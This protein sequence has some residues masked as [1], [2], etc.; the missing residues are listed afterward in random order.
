MT[1]IP[2]YLLRI[3]SILLVMLLC[4]RPVI[5]QDKITPTI[6]ADI[7]SQ[8]ISRGINDGDF[9]LQPSLGLSYKGLSLLAWGNCGISNFK[10][11][12]ELDITLS[13]TRWNITIGVTDNWVDNVDTFDDDGNPVERKTKY[14]DY[15]D[16]AG[17]VYE[18]FLGYDLGFLSATWYTNFAGDDGRTGRGK[19]AYSSYVELNS[20][21]KAFTCDWIA[22]LG[23]QPYGTSYY[24]VSGFAICNIAI[25]AQKSIQISKSFDIPLYASLIA[26]PSHQTLFFVVGITL[27]P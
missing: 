5:A 17:H 3:T 27:A 16:R 18:C 20:P 10:D 9:S 25:K 12:K 4:I 6:Q 13:Y 8:Y 22:T 7:V 11:T 23:F 14:F 15:S 24:D 1:I 21:F 26:N 2:R 19:R